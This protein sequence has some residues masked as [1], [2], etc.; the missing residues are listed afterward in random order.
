MMLHDY[1]SRAK[2]HILPQHIDTM[3]KEINPKTVIALHTNIE[4]KWNEKQCFSNAGK[5]YIIND[6]KII[7]KGE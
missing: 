5:W 4:D 1:T 2:S 6:G 3:I 7:E